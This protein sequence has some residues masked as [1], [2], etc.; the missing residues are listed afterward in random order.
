M[1][2]K[3]APEPENNVAVAVPPMSIP[4]LTLKFLSVVATKFPIPSYVLII[5][6][7]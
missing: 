4:F 2:V 1:L 6:N 5:L 7:Y 3:L